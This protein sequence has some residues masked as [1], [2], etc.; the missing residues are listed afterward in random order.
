MNGTISR[1]LVPVD[2]SGHSDQALRHATMLASRLG[3]TVELF[4]VVDDPFLSGAWSPEMYVPN[5]RE[6]LESLIGD[7]RQRLA[8]LQSSVSK[9]AVSVETAVATG[10]PASSILARAKAG[11]FDLIV[12]GTHGR[13][14]VSHVVMGSVAE[15]VVRKAECPVL[16]VKDAAAG[17][18][19]AAQ[20]TAAA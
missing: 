17:S 5:M 6:L 7:A 12:M 8:V 19:M 4:H 18:E 16:T 10:Q 9:E 11:R 1:I 14:G 20:D 2:F 15:R 3:A 13:T